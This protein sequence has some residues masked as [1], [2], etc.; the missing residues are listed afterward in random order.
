PSHGIYGP[1]TSWQEF[2][3]GNF[4][5]QDSEIGDFITSAPTASGG[6]VGQINVYNVTISGLSAGGVVHFDAYNS[7]VAGGHAK[8]INAPFSHDGEGGGDDETGGKGDVPEPA[9]L[10]IW[11]LGLGVV[12]LV[13]S[14]L[15]RKTA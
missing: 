3:L 11:G 7:V 5:K 8:Y 13:R 12:A 9:S 4:D 10:A 2:L 6:L 15:R 1:G 14:R